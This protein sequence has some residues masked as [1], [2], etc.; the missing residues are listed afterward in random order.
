M[1]PLAL[2][3]SLAV[4]TISARA[5]TT[6][7]STVFVNVEVPD[8]SPIGLSSTLQYSSSITSISQVE[9][10]FNVVGAWSGDL[11]AYISHNGG[12]AVLLNRPGRSVSQIDGS[13]VHD[14]IVLFS[15]GAATDIHTGLPAGGAV[16]GSFQPDGRLVDPADSFDTSPRSAFLSAFD[17][18]DPNGEWT[19]FVAD[20]S[21]G[22][23]AKLESWSLSISGV[24]E[25]SVALL[26]VVGIAFSMRRKR[27]SYCIWRRGA[28]KAIGG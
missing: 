2:L 27:S 15:D 28:E 19:L 7:S 11:Y 25:P 18:M 23:T 12:I 1:Q 10:G 4:I 24:P 16:N 20:L 17:G 8:N 6:A 26:G 14:L 3:A 13:G 9:I 5:A 22:D 21:T